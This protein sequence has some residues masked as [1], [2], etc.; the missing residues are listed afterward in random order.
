MGWCASL[1]MQWRGPLGGV[2]DRALPC[3]CVCVCVCQ[4]E[5]SGVLI[6][7]QYFPLHQQM[8]ARQTHALSRAS[9]VKQ[10]Q[11]ASIRAAAHAGVGDIAQR[12]AAAPAESATL[13]THQ[14]QALN[15]LRRMWA[16]GKHTIFADEPVSRAY[17]HTHTCSLV[18]AWHCRT[19]QSMTRLCK[20]FS[21]EAQ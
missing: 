9:P 14:L 18:H 5:G 17:T 13:Y 19:S 10:Q 8:W 2:V 6:Q 21:P 7:P 20:A 3:V 4:A 12:A 16:A 15:A 11:A 1:Q